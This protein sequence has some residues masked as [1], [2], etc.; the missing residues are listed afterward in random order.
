M[1]TLDVRTDDGQQL[2]A[3]VAH[4]DGI[5]GLSLRHLS[6]HDDVD[7]VIARVDEVRD[8]ERYVLRPRHL[9]TT[10]PHAHPTSHPFR[11]RR[12]P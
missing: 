10:A 11:P 3:V 5:D 6:V 12:F 1:D 8:Q 7:A 2:L 4:A 9:P